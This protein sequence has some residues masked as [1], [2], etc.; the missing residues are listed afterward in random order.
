MHTV[1]YSPRNSLWFPIQSKFWNDVKDSTWSTMPRY[2]R[3]SERHGLLLRLQS[4]SV[5]KY[6]CLQAFHFSQY[7]QEMWSYDCCISDMQWVLDTDKWKVALPRSALLSTDAPWASLEQKTLNGYGHR[8]HD[9]RYRGMWRNGA[10]YATP[11]SKA[12][13]KLKES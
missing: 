2:A 12:K 9:N 4:D 3:E 7:W 10:L 8:Y 13:G 1:C 5:S 6:G 11:T